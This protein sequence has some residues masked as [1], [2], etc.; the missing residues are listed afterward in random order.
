MAA[1]YLSETFLSLTPRATTYISSSLP[2]L[3]PTK[4]SDTL[5]KS[6][7]SFLQPLLQ[8]CS[9][10]QVSIYRKRNEGPEKGSDLSRALHWC[11]FKTPL[12]STQLPVYEAAWVDSA[13]KISFLLCFGFLP[14]FRQTHSP[15]TGAARGS[16]SSMATGPRRQERILQEEKVLLC[17][18]YLQ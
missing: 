5:Y 13:V 2:S 10:L 16:G 7:V 11:A 17:A 14:I 12:Y 15:A 8:L 3:S 1:C 4:H 18:F 9:L 6:Q